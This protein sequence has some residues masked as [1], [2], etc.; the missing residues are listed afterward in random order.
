[1]DGNDT[2]ILV[3]GAFLLT[4]A[5]L[6]GKLLS[7]GYRIPLQNLTGD[8]GFYIYQQVYPILGMVMVLAL[9]GFPS[10]ISKLTTEM[11][12][13]G[14]ELSFRSF[15]VPVFF[16]LFVLSTFLFLIMYVTA[17]Y[18][19]DWIG[20]MELEGVYRFAAFTFILIPFL[21]IGRGTF[22]GIGD[23]RPT[24]YSQ[25]SEQFIRVV[26]II[27][28]AVWFS[29]YG[30]D[31]YMIGKAAVFAALAAGLVAFGVLSSFFI[32]RQPLINNTYPVPWSFYI[33]SLLVFGLFFSLNHMLLLII[34]FA[35]T[36]TLFPGLLQYGLD[37][38]PAME[39]KGV[40]DRGQP[41]IQLGMV[42]GSSFSLALIPRISKRR[43]A[44]D[45]IV[46]VNQ[47]R[48]ALSFSAYIAVGATLGLILIFPEANLLLYKNTAGT[49]SLQILVTAILLSSLAITGATILQGLGYM[50]GPALFI[51]CAFILKWGLNMVLVPRLGITG[52]A[53]ATIF[54]LLILTIA[55]F[56]GLNV[57]LPQLA[58]LKKL[59]WR[60]LITSGVGMTVYIIV[61]QFIMSW[62]YPET[63]LGM[64]MYVVFTVLSGGLVYLYL[65]LKCKAFSEEE[66]AMLPFARV[67][68]RIR[69]GRN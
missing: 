19:S 54:S 5:G 64:L 50:K 34:Q 69:R 53:V 31:I 65:L 14:K 15:Y 43:L 41:F 57:K 48:S 66:L 2:K 29:I 32:K 17:P 62:I 7:A 18:L 8:V 20:D 16:I 30:E 42:L 25:V 46:F 13:S 28:A 3:K 10:A 44:D 9:Y 26:I 55:I 38:I 63:R 40:F 47:I 21:A 23:M 60:A 67:F 56:H 12:T 39:A 61:I 37:R 52:S 58:F 68:I 4:V 22:Q 59:R 51:G 49:G 27:A 36:F 24:A 45:P 1:M 33:K 35:D 11:K 6:I